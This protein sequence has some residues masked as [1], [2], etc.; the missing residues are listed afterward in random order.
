MD[1]N[2]LIPIPTNNTIAL[3]TTGTK[4]THARKHSTY[5]L[6]ASEVSVG[7]IIALFPES[8]KL[9]YKEF[10]GFFVKSRMGTTVF[11]KTIILFCGIVLLVFICVQKK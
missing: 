8:I 2:V 5:T 1:I 9:C 4:Q 10:Y 3:Q 11:D 6:C 7:R